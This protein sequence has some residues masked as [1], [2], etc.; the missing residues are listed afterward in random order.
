MF[1]TNE[2]WRAL[3]LRC[4]SDKYP[5]LHNPPAPTSVSPTKEI[6]VEFQI[7]WKVSLSHLN[8]DSS[9]TFSNLVWNSIKISSV[10]NIHIMTHFLYHFGWL[11]GITTHVCNLVLVINWWSASRRPNNTWSDCHIYWDRRIIHC[12]TMLR[13]LKVRRHKS[14]SQSFVFRR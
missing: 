13:Q 10:A 12:T 3:S 7:Q 4:V 8:E 2:I 14:V 1:W 5:I 11:T 6:S 9:S